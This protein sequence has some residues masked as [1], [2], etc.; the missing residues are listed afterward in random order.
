MAAEQAA[1][2][3]AF[4]AAMQATT[5]KAVRHV[6]D[7]VLDAAVISSLR[8]HLGIDAR[9]EQATQPQGIDAEAGCETVD[10]PADRWPS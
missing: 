8:S 3:K 1:F 10:H 7:R 2:A 9:P 5:P 6:A 4:M